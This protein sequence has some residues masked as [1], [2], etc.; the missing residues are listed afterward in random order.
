MSSRELS[1]W[2][3][4]W[5]DVNA[6]GDDASTPTDDVTSMSTHFVTVEKGL[7]TWS[8]SQSRGKDREKFRIRKSKFEAK[9]LM[10]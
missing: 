8:K 9:K 4:F 5:T 10:L 6:N 1:C 2:A 3:G 7:K